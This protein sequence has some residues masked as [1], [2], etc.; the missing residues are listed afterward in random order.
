MVASKLMKLFCFNL[1]LS[2]REHIN[3][4]PSTQI[5]ASS[6]VPVSIAAPP[7]AALLNSQ[8][9]SWRPFLWSWSLPV[10][11]CWLITFATFTERPSGDINQSAAVVWSN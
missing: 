3:F 10:D 5:S 9:V 6:F 11:E 1:P 7:L 8:S 2:D 4:S